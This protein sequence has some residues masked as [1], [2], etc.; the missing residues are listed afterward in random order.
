MGGTVDLL[1]GFSFFT[2]FQLLEILVATCIYRSWRKGSGPS[3]GPDVE[4][5]EV[6]MEEKKEE[7]E[8]KDMKQKHAESIRPADGNMVTTLTGIFTL[9]LKNFYK[10]LKHNIYLWD[11]NPGII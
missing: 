5:G 11:F 3:P 2:I 6:E 4:G 8:T 7:K 10:Y 1:I 9:W